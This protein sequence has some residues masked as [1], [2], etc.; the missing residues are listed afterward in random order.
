MA[1]EAEIL[2]SLFQGEARS[3][4]F[5]PTPPSL[6]LELSTIMA[7]K[8]DPFSP[9]TVGDPCV[10]DVLSCLSCSSHAA[11]SAS[12]PGPRQHVDR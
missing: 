10:A 4:V 12:V 2:S 8:G 5:R 7:K 1:A 6:A 9:Q 11:L 3:C